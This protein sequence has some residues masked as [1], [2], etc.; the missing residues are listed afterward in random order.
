MT[1]DDAREAP[2]I[3]VE[4][5]S[6]GHGERLVLEQLSLTIARGAITA[7]VG[8]NASGKSTLLSALARQLTPR[9]G[10]VHLDGRDVATF[11]RKALGRRM[12][13][14]PQSPLV[15]DGI[16]VADLVGRAR[17]PHQRW[18]GQWNAENEE[19]VVRAL[20]LTDTAHLASRI[21]DELSGGQR[22]R[23]WLAFAIAQDAPVMLLDEPSTFLDLATQGEVLDILADLNAHDG[24]TIVLVLHDLSQAARYA[25]EMIALKD[26]R[27]EATGS[28]EAVLTEANLERIFG[29][30]ARVIAD[31]VTATPLVV[32]L[33]RV[34]PRRSDAPSTDPASSAS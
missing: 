7:I 5:L 16:T 30:R 18:F 3:L 9:H 10:S 1:D 31:P 23:V 24:R 20:E 15:P 34:S 26:G 12:G 13:L 2:A 6:A 11:G 27:V 32:P 14:L 8:A 25:H 28:P 33:R 29:L 17:Y 22:Q 19:A 4:N 21:V